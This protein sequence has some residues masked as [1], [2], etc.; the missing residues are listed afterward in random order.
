[1]PGGRRGSRKRRS[2]CPTRW[3]TPGAARPGDGGGAGGRIDTRNSHGTGCSLSSAM[4]TVQ[5][6]V[7]NW[8]RRCGRSSRGCWARWR[9]RRLDVGPGNGPVH[10]FHHLGHAGRS[11]TGGGEFAAALRARRRG[12]PRRHLRPGLHPR[13]GRSTLPE[14]EFAYYLA[15]D[16]IYLNGYSRVLARAA[17]LAP[18]EAEQLFWARSAQTCL[19]VES[20]LHRSWLSTRPGGARP[21]PVTKSYVDHLL[22]A[23]VSGATRSSWR[24]SCR[25]SGSTPRW[26]QPCTGSSSPTVPP[27]APLRRVAGTYADEG[28]R[29]RHPAGHRVSRTRRRR[30]A[31]AGNGGHGPGLP[32]VL[33]ATKWTSSTRRG[34]TPDPP[35]PAQPVG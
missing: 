25:A 11:R 24:R 28:L 14:N 15:Q 27:G 21:W 13:T 2:G 30:Q 20:E 26:V 34:C 16:A 32:A 19:E 4:A 31:S 10:H 9:S 6:R 7:G 1:M 5:A 29:R 12:R 22:A 18:T 3:S 23:S 17:A 35:G 33:A 8:E